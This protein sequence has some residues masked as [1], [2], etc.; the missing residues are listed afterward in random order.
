MPSSTSFPDPNPPPRRENASA[1]LPLV[2]VVGVVAFIAL[3]L[4]I[5]TTSQERRDE[6]RRANAPAPGA[7][8]PIEREALAREAALIR[9]QAEARTPFL[10]QGRHGAAAGASGVGTHRPIGAPVNP[11]ADR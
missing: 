3:V 4:W 11:L 7:V 5:W 2:V 1:L 8:D 10:V 6:E 9:A